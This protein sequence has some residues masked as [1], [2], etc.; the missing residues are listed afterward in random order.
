MDGDSA[1]L[2]S[3]IREAYYRYGMLVVAATGSTGAPHV[4]FPA[5][6]PEVIAVASAGTQDDPDVRSW[7]SNWG[8]QVDVAAPG[9]GIA[10]T[11]AEG[12]CP[13]GWHCLGD[14]PYAIASGTSFAAPMVTA[15]AALL[16]SEQPELPPYL[17]QGII[18]ATASDLPDA[19]EMYW[20]GAGRIRALEALGFAR[21]YLGTE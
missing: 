13:D 19:G 12:Y 14:Q 18:A 5:R 1:V 6:M 16:L 10:G 15:L 21:Y 7:F 11:V 3:A 4:Q 9:Y 20:D 17:V 8:P 2:A